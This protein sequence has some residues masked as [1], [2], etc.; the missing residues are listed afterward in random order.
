M[1]MKNTKLLKKQEPTG[2]IDTVRW[3]EL[4]KELML[5]DEFQKPLKELVDIGLKIGGLVRRQRKLL[6]MIEEM[7]VNRKNEKQKK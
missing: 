4:T 2:G 6:V 5:D 1:K 3:N 7:I